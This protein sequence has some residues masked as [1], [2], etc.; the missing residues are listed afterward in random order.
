MKE[1]FENQNW[2]INIIVFLVPIGILLLAILTYFKKNKENDKFNKSAEVER[3]NDIEINQ[4]IN[5][6]STVK[7]SRN[8]KINQ[9]DG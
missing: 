9:K 6:K 5:S 7:D 3:S 2:I 8:V 4:S 1:L